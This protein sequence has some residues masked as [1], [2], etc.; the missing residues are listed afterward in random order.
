MHRRQ[1]LHA[2]TLAAAAPIALVPARAQ[3]ATPT[4]DGA[5][6]IDRVSAVAPEALLEALLTV[7]VTTPL[8]PRD[9]PPAEPVPWEDSSDID[10][11]GTVGGVIFETGR[12]AV[13]NPLAIATA[14]VHPDAASASAAL[15]DVGPDEMGQLLGMPWFVQDY[16][17]YAVAVAQ[18][19]FL[20]LAGG[21]DTPE[22]DAL[23]AIGATPAPAVDRAPSLPLRAIANLTAMLDHLEDVLASLHA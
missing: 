14:I 15:A 13:D 21:A 17:D 4:G 2:V 3:V 19:D 8:L 16:G 6:L 11:I 12:D 22:D 18:V 23:A 5:S 1:F 7:P 10:L 9:T 20:L